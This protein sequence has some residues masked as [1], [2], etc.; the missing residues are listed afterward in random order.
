MKTA[1]IG[2]LYAPNF[3][4]PNFNVIIRLVLS[5]YSK[6][7]CSQI[8]ELSLVTMTYWASTKIAGL[9]TK[10]VL[11]GLNIELYK[12]LFK[13]DKL[14]KVQNHLAGVVLCL[15]WSVSATDAQHQ[16]HWLSIKQHITYEIATEDFVQDKPES[17]VYSWKKDSNLKQKKW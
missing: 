11:L 14:L 3:R 15:P 9:K 6:H 8:L 1:S 16:L 7:Y 2:L 17:Q 4:V 13:L 5:Q 10:Y 12:L